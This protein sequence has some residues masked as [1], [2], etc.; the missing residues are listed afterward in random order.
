MRSVYLF[1][2]MCLL[3]ILGTSALPSELIFT[4]EGNDTTF[5]Q[6]LKTEEIPSLRNRMESLLKAG[7]IPIVVEE[8]NDVVWLYLNDPCGRGYTDIDFKS[9]YFE[10]IQDLFPLK[11]TDKLKQSLKEGNKSLIKT[12]GIEYIVSDEEVISRID[13]D[14]FE[15]C[16]P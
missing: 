9:D 4:Y 8:K 5:R 6:K 16:M 12:L 14:T 10:T 11:L 3:P 7:N 15:Q 1:V 2:L 13:Y